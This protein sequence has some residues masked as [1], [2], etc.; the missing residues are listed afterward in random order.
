LGTR[1]PVV[2]F[3]T[4][5]TTDE[6]KGIAQQCLAFWDKQDVEFHVITPEI[7]GCS[8]REFNRE[9][10]VYADRLAEGIHIV[11]DDDCIPEFDIRDALN[12]I[13][14]HE[15]FGTLSPW[16]TNCTIYPWTEIAA[17]ED[18]EVMEHCSVGIFRL[19]RK[20]M[21]FPPSTGVGYDR[22]HG[23]AIRAIGMK[24]GLLKKH[25]ILHLGEGKT[26]LWI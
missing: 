23:D 5:P 11:T 21:P 12:V 25:K 18:D 3:C 17:F 24:V 1:K 10:R 16:P 13:Q 4:A 7:V 20:G 9:R 19:S 22:T 26:S 14:G 15:Q 2:Y 6:R 8:V